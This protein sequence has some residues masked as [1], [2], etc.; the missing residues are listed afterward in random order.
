MV[1][2]FYDQLTPFYHLVH[3]DWEASIESQAE[4]YTRIIRT[5]WGDSVTRILDASC[6]IGTQTIGLA[7]RGFQVTASDLS[8][9]AVER[10]RKEAAA[11]DLAISFSVCDMCRLSSC[12]GGGFD[13]VLSAGN[14]LPHLLSDEEI[15]LALREMHACLR[16]GGGCLVTTRRYDLEPRG[17]GILK[18]FGVRERDDKRYIIFQV[19]DFAGQLYDFAMYFLEEDKSTG[20]IETHVM[21]SRYYAIHPDHL[22]DL[23]QQAGFDRVRRVDDA[24]SHPAILVGTKAS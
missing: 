5:E 2:Q 12:H 4:L 24:A 22:M 7:A 11:R 3:E 10:A 23:M 20:L 9:E 18:P 16:P 14:S 15:L 13:V 17:R 21:R 19:W 8:P 6:G 1:G